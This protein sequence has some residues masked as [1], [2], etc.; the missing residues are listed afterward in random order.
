MKILT[1][2]I[3]SQRASPWPRTP[4]GIARAK[5]A[6]C[7]IPDLPDYID[8]CLISHDHYDHLDKPSVRT[9]R[10]RVGL[11]IVPTGTKEWMIAKGKVPAERVVELAWWESVKVGRSTNDDS[12]NDD[13]VVTCHHALHQNP[14]DAHPATTNPPG[15]NE[16]WISCLPVQHWCS[17]T[18]W[19]RNYRLWAS[20]AVLFPYQQ[21]FY[22]TGDT[23]LP[24]HFPLFDQIRSYL[25]WPVSLAAIPIGAYEPAILNDDSHV[26]PEQAI[27]IFQS[28]RTRQAVAIH[29]G[30][31]PL[32]EEPLEEPALWLSQAVV[33]AGLRPGAFVSIEQGAYLDCL[34]ATNRL[35]K[36]R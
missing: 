21:T 20:Y 2:P 12:T 26:N 6:A 31:F 16:L 19:D 9:L 5:P 29:H 1:D 22:F 3:F 32:S 15:L 11:W 4:I 25:P 27:Q 23:A 33:E 8:V 36:K 24:T 7:T 30:S 17:R 28:L 10:H 18:I 13:L 35:H 14:R 34:S